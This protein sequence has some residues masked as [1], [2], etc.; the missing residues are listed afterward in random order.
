MDLAPPRGTRDFF[1]AE[2]RSRDWL[3]GHFREVA[4]LFGF[5]E[6]DTPVVESEE[7]YTR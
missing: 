5:E 6:Y 1:P 7:L 2:L 3:F 4:R